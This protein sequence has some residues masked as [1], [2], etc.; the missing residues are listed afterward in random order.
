MREKGF[1]VLL[2]IL[3]LFT[4]TGCSSKKEIVKDA[5]AAYLDEYGGEVTDSKIDKYDGGMPENHIVMISYILNSKGMDYELDDYKDIYLIF[6]IN[7]KGEER[8]VVYVDG[9]II[10]PDDN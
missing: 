8:A 10:V 3:L 9:E 1:I 6:L 5:T 7:E 2:V 4:V